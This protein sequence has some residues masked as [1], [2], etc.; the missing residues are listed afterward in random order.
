M[1][2][3]YLVPAL[4]LVLGL[5]L[6][7]TALLKI[8]NLRGFSVIVASYGV[9]PKPLV[10]PLAYLQPLVEL[11]A[12]SWILLGRQLFWGALL[13]CVL[14]LA[15][16]FFVGVALVQKKKVQNCGCYG[17]A[18]KIPLSWKKF[19]ENVVWVLLFALLAFAVHV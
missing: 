11:V 10:K 7:I 13:G 5:L 1:N 16:T 4:R 8:P 3:F 9:L 14:M 2:L 12:G 18:F 6:I 19:V 17:V 15:A